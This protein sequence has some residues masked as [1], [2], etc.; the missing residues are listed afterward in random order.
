MKH[1]LF[2]LTILLTAMT[3]AMNAEAL[4]RRALVIGLG[5]QLDKSW[6]KIH[7]D[8]DAALISEK[9][10]VASFSDITTLV[11]SNATKAGITKAFNNLIRR[12]K[13]GDK[14]FI[15]FSGHGQRMTDLNGDEKDGLDECWIPYDAFRKYCDSDKGEKHL[16]DDEIAIFLTRLREKVGDSGIIAVFVDAC[17]SGDSTREPD[18][19]TESAIRGVIDNFIIPSEKPKERTEKVE[20]KW[21][22]VSACRNYQLNQEYN[23]HGK[24]TYILLNHP[25]L[26]EYHSDNDF[27][28]E[29][30]RLM[31]SRKYRGKYPQSPVMSGDKGNV[32][33]NLFH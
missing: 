19:G 7:G 33:Y 21:L 8:K 1:I 3:S 4:T 20:E 27:L 30:T 11:N 23:G 14:I 24:L 22:T 32:I 26:T 9:L 31:E 28:N 29:L 17:H 2:L 10:R 16:C 13:P 15:H 5:E 25:E 6:S 12:S 18:N